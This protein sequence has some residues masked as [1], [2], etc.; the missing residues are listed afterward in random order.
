[1]PLNWQLITEEALSS[2]DVDS[3]LQGVTELDRY[4]FQS[5]ISRLE[6]ED[7]R[8]SPAQLEG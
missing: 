1:M 8:W 3:L 2:L 7:A 4:S 5:I 6:K